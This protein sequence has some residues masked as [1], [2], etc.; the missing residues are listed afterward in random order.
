MNLEHLRSLIAPTTADNNTYAKTPF[1]FITEPHLNA[2]YT[3][4]EISIQ[5]YN[6]LR[7]D[8]DPTKSRK[9]KH[10]G[11][12]VYIHEDVQTT[13]E[14]KYAGEDLELVAFTDKKTGI[15]YVH[16]Y[17]MPGHTI[18]E[19]AL[20]AIEKEANTVGRTIIVGDLNMN[21]HRSR[22]QPAQLHTL[23]SQQLRDP[24]GQRLKQYV[25]FA[26]YHR[27]S[28]QARQQTFCS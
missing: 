1:A 15:R 12:L 7:Q 21:M 11:V 23:L 2:S 25:G 24:N 28:K 20:K 3:D 18:T 17:R 22:K 16:M 14:S 19:D 8:R 26:T 6:I 5:G 9:S 13:K 27:E 10:G 4:G